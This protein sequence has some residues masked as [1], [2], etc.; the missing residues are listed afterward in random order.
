MAVAQRDYYEV[1]GVPREADAKAI[2]DAFRELA[3]RYHPD[4]NKEPGAEDRFKE[5]AEA[6]AV[7][8]DPTKRAE[9]DRHGFAGVAGFST[10][11]LVGGINFDE[12]FGGLGFDFGFGGG[13]FDRFFGRHRRVGPLRG[14]NLEVDL[15][16]SLERVLSGGEE[17]VRV[18]RPQPCPACQGSGA[19]RGITP[20]PCAVCGG[21]GQKTTSRRHGNV[22]VQQIT[23]CEACHG[24][25]TI[26]EK[27]CPECAGRGE[28]ERA[29]TLTVRIPRG[30]EEGTA[31]RIASH[32]FPSTQTGGPP[33]DLFVI[34][35][36]IPDPR[37]ER[38]QT[39]LWRVETIGVA[40]AVLGTKLTIPTLDG[41]VTVTVPAGTQPGEILRLR[42]K[43]L[44]VFGGKKRGDL[45][46]SLQVHVPE[47]LRPE[48]RE[49]YERLQSLGHD[50][51]VKKRGRK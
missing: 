40:D 16:I 18:S 15:P 12:I 14:A 6:Y 31:L 4:R 26:I 22:T 19:E 49:L 5:I 38:R 51:V 41:P 9:Y 44:P 1:L 11:D 25:G 17:T 34:V 48:E 21:K 20:K 32:G 7:L 29:E 10:E 39:S 45:F 2:K 35:H 30:V 27:L 37:F 23:A 24:R 28:V 13:I 46:V 47:Q 36:S 42:D 33:G 8:S 3:L 43:G 50:G